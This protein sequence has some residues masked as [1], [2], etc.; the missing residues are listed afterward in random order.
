MSSAFVNE[1]RDDD[2]PRIH[3]ALP[4]FNDPT[5]PRAAA[6]AL[7]QA[8]CD[9]HTTDAEE[10]T[11]Y[12]FGEPLLHRHVRALLEQEEARPEGEQDRRLITI[13]KRFLRA[14]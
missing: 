14:R 4:H 5:Y 7:V 9:G 2:I 12:R 10:A 3:F 6:Y 1:D 13:A 8:A 11:G